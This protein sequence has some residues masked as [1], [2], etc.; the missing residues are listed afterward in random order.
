MVRG[1]VE[2]WLGA[3]VPLVVA[4]TFLAG[5]VVRFLFGPA[6]DASAAPFRILVWSAALVVLRWVYMDSLR[7]TGHQNLDLR[8]AITSATLNVGLNILLIPRFGMLGAASATVFADLV[9]FVMSHHYFRR[10]VLSDEPLQ[11]LAGPLLGG[12]AMCVVLWFARPLNWPLQL[13]L[14]IAAYLLIQAQFGAL[15]RLRALFRQ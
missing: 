7:A 4:G 8:C 9:W 13:V 12:S 11:P 5:P 2:L 3:V 10:V 6:Y 14:S 15:T 1:T